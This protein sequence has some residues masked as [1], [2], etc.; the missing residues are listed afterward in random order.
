MAEN[1]K[2][3]LEINVNTKDGEKNID[4]LSDKTQE[5]TKSAKQGQGAFSTLGNTIKSLGIV[6]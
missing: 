6:S 2:F 3:N 4:K 1:Q 5:A